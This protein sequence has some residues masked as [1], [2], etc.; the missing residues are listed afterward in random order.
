MGRAVN[1]TLSRSL[2]TESWDTGAAAQAARSV[3]ACQPRS[4]VTPGT[5]QRGSAGTRPQ[6]CQLLRAVLWEKRAGP[7]PGHAGLAATSHRRHRDPRTSTNQG[8]LNGGDKNPHW[9]EGWGT[10]GTCRRAVGAPG[11]MVGRGSPPTQAPQHQQHRVCRPALF[12][13]GL[14]M[15]PR[16]RSSPTWEGTWPH[17]PRLR[18]HRSSERS[19]PV[20]GI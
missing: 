13:P 16:Y 5:T 12:F 8:G 2:R 17:T 4:R 7:S 19:A 18:R 15:D 1:W 6:L 3:S 11:W 14:T 10:L 9:G 20:L